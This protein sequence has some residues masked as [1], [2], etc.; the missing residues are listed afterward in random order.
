ML[1]K[2]RILLQDTA[3]SISYTLKDHNRITFS[4]VSVFNL[5]RLSNAFYAKVSLMA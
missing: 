3:L 4:L 2:K 5:N 1:L